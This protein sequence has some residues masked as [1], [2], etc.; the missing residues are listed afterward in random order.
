MNHKGH[1]NE[2]SDHQPTKLLIVKQILLVPILENVQTTFW[3]KCILM[4]RCKWFISENPSRIASSNFPEV[5]S[6]YFCLSEHRTWGMIGRPIL[7]ECSIISALV[8]LAQRWKLTASQEIIRFVNRHTSLRF[9]LSFTLKPLHAR[10]M[11]RKRILEN[12]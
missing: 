8:R 3:R 5:I 6:C 10:P 7:A 2:E 1:E 11:E 9:S 4:S 12:V